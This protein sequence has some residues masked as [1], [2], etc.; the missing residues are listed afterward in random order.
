SGDNEGVWLGVDEY[1][2]FV[3]GSGLLIWHIN[4]KVI[5]GAEGLAF[6]N[7]PVKPGI[8]LEEADGYRDIGQPVFERLRQIE[9]SEDDAFTSVGISTFDQ[10]SVPSSHSVDGWATGIEIKVLSEW[11]DTAQIS[12]RFVRNFPNWPRELK[13][14]RR[15]QGSDLNGDNLDDLIVETSEGLTVAGANG[16]DSWKLPRAYFLVSGDIDD[17]KGDELIVFREGRIEAWSLGENKE[18]WGTDF[19]RVPE[20]AI[21]GRFSGPEKTEE[22]PILAVLSSGQLYEYEADTGLLRAVIDNPEKTFTGIYATDK[23]YSGV[24][25]GVFSSQG[26]NDSPFTQ[27]FGKEIDGTIFSVVAGRLGNVSING[28]HI[29]IDDSLIA[30]CSM[31]DVDGDGQL[32]G[33]FSGLYSVY[34]IDA[35]GIPQADFPL[36][37][38]AYADAG[39]ILFQPLLADLDGD[40]GQEI[41]VTTE[42]GIYAFDHLGS[43]MH[44]FP[45]L[46]SSRP[47]SAPIFLDIN[48]DGLSELAALDSQFVYVWDLVILDYEVTSVAWG[49][50]NGKANGWR[51]A[52]GELDTIGVPKDGKKLMPPRLVYCYPN[53]VGSGDM[54]HLRFTLLDDADVELSVLDALGL[55]V[56]TIRERV[57]S[58]ENEITWAV[59]SYV[60]GLY[61]CRITARTDQATETHIVKMAIIQ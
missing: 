25:S 7:D 8:A 10:Y 34:S 21:V 48:G 22:I 5:T 53:P 1:D 55:P 33:I 38:P 39:R 43:I 44:G 49:Q 37:L 42:G 41:I 13:H 4:E 15:L 52:E 47:Q 60:S 17:Q 57:V 9:G 50:L 23:G 45:L 28:K 24:P 27:V 58:G 61:F 14:G 3:P 12:V 19:D 11:E 40:G 20:A 2:S 29:A 46:L 36:R 32:E 6:N 18:I 35:K 26:V 16:I 59:G 30:P 31:G 54:A 56:Q 51:F